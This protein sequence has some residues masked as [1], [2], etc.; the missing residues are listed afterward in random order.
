MKEQPEQ[1][2][3]D[4]SDAPITPAEATPGEARTFRTGF[5]GI[6]GRPNVGKSTL[7]NRI[8]G[9]K[10]AIATPKAQTTRDRIKGIRT[11]KDWQAIFVDTPG[12]HEPRTKLNRYMVDLAV[13]T[14]AEVD[15]AYLL[16][17]VAKVVERPEKTLEETTRIIG[18]L[19]EAGTPSFLLLNKIDRFEDKSQLLPIIESYSQLHSFVEVVP[20]SAKR[21]KNLDRLLE[22]TRPFLPESPALFSE[23]DLTDRPMRFIAKEIIREQLL[24]Q[25]A[26]ELPYTAAVN[27]LDWKEKEDGVIVIHANIHVARRS[28]KPIVVGRGGAQI[29]AIGEKSR[30][31][32]EHLVERRVYLDLRVKVDEDWLDNDRSLKELGYDE[33][34]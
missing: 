20:V 26:Q 18:Y 12:I 14:V 3:V 28:H 27:I 30:E 34:E 32:I 2:P 11:F 24:Y 5:V 6:I 7:M 4:A 16:I 8:L 31:R 22:A 15:L 13:A 10:V 29:K 1:P 33:L 17:D 25:L 23:D 9:Q 21:G 19:K